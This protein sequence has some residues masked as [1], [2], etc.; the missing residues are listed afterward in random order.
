MNLLF[1]YGKE[2][3]IEL[4]DETYHNLAIDEL[5]DTIGVT[6]DDKRIID[7]LLRILPRDEKTVI[8]RQEVLKDF[9]SDDK[10]CSDL[11][12]IIG[13]LNIL[14]EFHKHS[15]FSI[16]RKSSLWNLISYME[17]MEVYIKILEDMI[18]F[19]DEHEVKSRG[20]SEISELLKEA[21][22]EDRIEELKEIVSSLHAEISTL[23]SIT[24]GINLTPEL[25]PAEVM[26]L[27]FDTLPFQSKMVKTSL[28]MSIAARRKVQYI[29]PSPFMK[30]VNDDMEKELSK[31]VQKIKVELKN[32][33]N[34]KGYFLLDICNDLKTYL[35]IAKYAGKLMNKGYELCMPQIDES[36]KS[37][38]MKNIYNIRLT[39]RHVENIVKNDFAFSE[40]EK[41]FILT[42]PNRGGKT[43]L[44]QAVGINA[45]FAA[46]GLFVAASS[47]TGYLFRN[48]YTHFPADENQTLD[49]GR[50]GEEAVRVQNIVKHADNKTLV[51]LNET[52]SSTSAYDGLYLAT[53]LVH[54]FKHKDVPM[55]FN[56]HIHELACNTK[57]MNEWEGTSNVI[58]LNMEIVNNQNTFRIL[59]KEPDRNSY[60]KNI[61]S[62]YGVTYEQMLDSTE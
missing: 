9:L 5:V 45:L 4:T 41:L 44:T 18:I 20:L 39:T 37:V 19:F 24:V 33:I 26:V 35:L 36:M 46:Q 17:E 57:E 12:E 50:L 42:G 49:L 29:E 10:F 53:D 3:A 32:Y 23:K 47:Y 60:A 58:S 15:H 21:I 40:N 1:P 30:Y 38:V 27:G 7:N 62:K 48:I 54:I 2:N 31:T 61:A 8:Y 43:M 51:L 56:T 34:F 28:G 59:R 13:N 11:N 25:R 14:E 22:D 16:E 6:A 55:I 52:Y